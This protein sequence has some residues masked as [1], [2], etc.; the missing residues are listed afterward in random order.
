MIEALPLLLG[1]LRA[2]G[3]AIDAE[4]ES[5]IYF[6]L[7]SLSAGD[8]T[9]I[10]IADLSRLIAPIVCG[11]AEE[12]ATFHRRI[13]TWF[14]VH[15]GGRSHGSDER[16]RDQEELPALAHS[17]HDGEK[18]RTVETGREIAKGW[19]L[20]GAAMLICAGLIVSFRVFDNRSANVVIA[21][22][23]QPTPGPPRTVPR[24][25]EPVE[26]PPVRLEHDT[27]SPW[28][29]VLINVPFALVAFWLVMPMRSRRAFFV[30]HRIVLRARF[31]DLL[32]ES[33]GLATAWSEGLGAHVRDLRAQR[34]KPSRQLDVEK[35]VQSTVAQ[36]GL[37]TPRHK[38]RRVTPEYLVLAE[39]LGPGDHQASLFTELLTVFRDGGVYVDIHWF[40]Q[41]PRISQAS[42]RVPAVSLE[43]LA[44]TYAESAAV[45]MGSVDRFLDPVS[46][47]AKPWTKVFRAWNRP[48]LLTTKLSHEWGA[49]E[50]EL[51][52]FSSLTL[53][54]PNDEGLSLLSST[55]GDP[56]APP[57]ATNDGSVSTRRP[58]L[59]EALESEVYLWLDPSPPDQVTI[60]ATID[61]LE[62]FLG[63]EGFLW[64]CA[65]AVLPKLKWP[66]TWHLAKKLCIT[67][68]LSLSDPSLLLRVVSLPWFRHGWMPSWLRVALLATLSPET[69]ARVNLILDELLFSVGCRDRHDPVLKIAREAEAHSR[70]EAYWSDVAADF[71]DDA[72]LLE[73]LRSSR[74]QPGSFRLSEHVSSRLGLSGTRSA[75]ESARA[76]LGVESLSARA[77]IL[78]A[79]IEREQVSEVVPM[80]DQKT[81]RRHGLDFDRI[82]DL[83]CRTNSFRMTGKRLFLYKSYRDRTLH[84]I[85]GESL[86]SVRARRQLALRAAT[87]A[88]SAAAALSAVF[89][90]PYFRQANPLFALLATALLVGGPFW[91]FSFLLVRPAFRRLTDYPMVSVHDQ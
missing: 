66:V 85:D 88:A 43:T 68:A 25:S 16:A 56:A 84:A 9:A 44:N 60:Q 3:F 7:L 89:Y 21:P 33:E 29:L 42:N 30:D 27:A 71:E 31:F 17:I 34:N 78:Q 76:A 55:S 35:T 82:A 13:A 40:R 19:R 37:F 69:A 73:F 46:G 61:R 36:G 79:A 23:A 49:A 59:V 1:E 58:P 47:Q 67:D 48:V 10:T 83:K 64:I 24:S 72:I 39:R 28:L 14:R 74:P 62:E 63:P 45:V 8:S 50:T 2:G 57:T 5:S 91:M 20:L 86:E 32:I 70:D 18:R 87:L 4:Q 80:N 81:K 65:C 51:A 26:T 12:Q 54:N 77:A 22:V 41:D 6:L 75:W 52:R 15:G 90:E 38:A 53:V 11:S